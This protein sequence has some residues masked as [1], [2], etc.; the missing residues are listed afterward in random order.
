MAVWAAVLM[1]GGRGRE[2]IYYVSISRLELLYFPVR[3][4]LL[5]AN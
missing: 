3:N 5:C 2:E 4:I 1:T